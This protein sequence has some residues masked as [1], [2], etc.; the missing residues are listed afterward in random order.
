[1]RTYI[2]KS[3]LRPEEHAEEILVHLRGKARDIARV[4]TRNSDIDI[5]CD[6]EAIYVLL[7]K[8][9]D[10]APCSPLPLA[11]FYTTLPEKGEEAFDYWLTLHRAVDIAVERLKEHGKTLDSPGTE[12]T[13]MFIRN[14]PSP[15]L[16]MTFRSKAMAKWTAH[17]VQ[18]ILCKHHSGMTS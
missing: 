2:K 11:D 5:T 16:S 1:M 17:E 4:G 18:E 15:E 10:S 12:V 14:C 7:R 3:N 9:F 13:R 6:P 8:H